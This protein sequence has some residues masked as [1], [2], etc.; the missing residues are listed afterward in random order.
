MN[1]LNPQ[2]LVEPDLHVCLAYCENP[3][4]HSYNLLFIIIDVLINLLYVTN[5]IIDI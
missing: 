1:D 5:Y 3:Y 4:Y 2:F